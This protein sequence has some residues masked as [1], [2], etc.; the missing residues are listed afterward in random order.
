[1]L[2]IAGV[3]VTYNRKEKLKQNLECLLNQE[4]PLNKIY[5]IDN[6]ST[7]G[8]YEYIKNI[9]KNHSKI[10]YIKLKTNGG[11]AKGFEVGMKKAYEDGNDCIWGMDD[12]AFPKQNALKEL[13]KV[14]EK[15]SQDTCL[16]SN[17]SPTDKIEYTV[18][19]VKKWVFVGFFVPRIVIQQIGFPRGDLFIYGDDDEYCHRIIKA[20]FHIYKVRSSR[21]EHKFNLSQEKYSKKIFGKK[22]SFYKIPNWRLYYLI[23]NNILKFKYTE[24]EKYKAIFIDTSKIFIKLLILNPKQIPIFLKAFWHGIIGKSGKVISP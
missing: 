22:I 1:M 14:Y 20:G 10:K 24:K 15:M 5:L 7:D 21:I 17:S 11:G 9:I 12:D 18:K 2:K 6:C 16:W 4:Y 23:R 8:T 19:E 3:V 13:I